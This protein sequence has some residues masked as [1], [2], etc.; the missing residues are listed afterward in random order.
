[1]FQVGD[2]VEIVEDLHLIGLARLSKYYSNGAICK[3]VNVSDEIICI[4]VVEHPPYRTVASI[5]LLPHEQ[6]AIRKI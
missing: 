3:V 5:T 4:Q 1:M 6:K 2:K